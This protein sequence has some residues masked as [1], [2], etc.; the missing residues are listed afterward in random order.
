M[1]GFAMVTDT[2]IHT[3]YSNCCYGNIHAVA[4]IIVAIVT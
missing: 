1:K 3:V 2:H 4:R